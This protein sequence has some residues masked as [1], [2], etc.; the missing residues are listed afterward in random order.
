MVK[1]HDILLGGQHGPF[2]S[3][4]GMKAFEVANPK[5]TANRDLQGGRAGRKVSA[6]NGMHSARRVNAEEA[7]TSQNHCAFVVATATNLI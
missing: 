7:S 4:S 5:L 3:N 2:M 6:A 1:V